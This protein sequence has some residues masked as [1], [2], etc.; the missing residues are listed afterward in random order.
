MTWNIHRLTTN[1]DLIARAL[2]L[3]GKLPAD[4]TGIIGIARTGMV[5]AALIAAHLHLPLG[6]V[7]TFIRSG[8]L[9]LGHGVRYP[10]GEPAAGP[11]AIIDDGVSVRGT[12][13][14]TARNRLRLAFPGR[15]FVTAACFVPNRNT[16]IDY[17]AESVEERDCRLQWQLLNNDLV[18]QYM[19]DFDGVLCHDPPHGETDDEARWTAIF[20]DARPLYLPRWKPVGAIVTCRLEK[21]RDISQQ[22]LRRQ[23]AQ[24][25][26]LIMC[27]AGSVAQREAMR[28]KYG[29]WKGQIYRDAAEMQLFV[30][31]CPYQAAEIRRASGKPVLC[32]ASGEMVP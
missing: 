32:A 30:E 26:Q 20:R 7:E 24:Y 16:W 23:R 28:R 9:W 11:L 14:R 2:E 19:V 1:A 6:E 15:Q 10:Y 27:P 17:W 5:P 25:A 12:A 4:T 3:A 13:M 21:Y 31:S 22:W 18:G 29:Q 8:G